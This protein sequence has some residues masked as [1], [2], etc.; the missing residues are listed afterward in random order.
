M[1]AHAAGRALSAFCL[2]RQLRAR[3][4][5]DLADGMLAIL[6]A[7]QLLGPSTAMQIAR[8]TEM[9]EGAVRTQLQRYLDGPGGYVRREKSLY[10]LT[11]TGRAHAYHVALTADKLLSDALA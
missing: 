10:S 1:R 5:T 4:T 3:A 7:L 6:L 9:T 11:P 8:R 2:T